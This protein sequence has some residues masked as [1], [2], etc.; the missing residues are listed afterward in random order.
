[1]SM[2]ELA[3]A[4][5]VSKGHVS[6]VENGLTAVTVKTMTQLAMGLRL[7]ALFLLAFPEDDERSEVVDMLRKLEP[8]QLAKLKK[9]LEAQVVK[10]RKR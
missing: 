2:A 7:P 10:K 3:A 1:M 8:H 6:T 4:S 9:E 5:R